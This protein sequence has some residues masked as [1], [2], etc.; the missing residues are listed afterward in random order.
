M[1]WPRA[2]YWMRHIQNLA[3]YHKFSHVSLFTSYSD[4]FTYIVAYLEPCV[5]LAYSE[6]YHIQNPGIFRTRDIFWTLSSHILAYLE[7]SVTLSFWEPCDI[8]NLA[9]FRIL[10]CLK[11]EAYSEPSI[12]RHIQTYLKMKVITTVAFFFAH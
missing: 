4:I 8:E 2:I 12:F 3:Y 1:E 5:T 6:P 11:T 9:I 10:T 7:R